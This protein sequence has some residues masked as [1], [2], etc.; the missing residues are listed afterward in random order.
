M[1]LFILTLL[2]H[3]PAFSMD[4]DEQN[5]APVVKKFSKKRA[6]APTKTAPYSSNNKKIKSSKKR[7]NAPT[8]TETAPSW[9]SSNNKI[10]IKTTETTQIGYF[11]GRNLYGYIDRSFTNN[12]QWQIALDKGATKTAKGT[13]GVKS[14]NDNVL[15]LKINANERLYATG[16]HKNDVGDYVAIFDRVTNHEGITKLANKKNNFKIYEDCFR[17]SN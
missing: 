7:A 10:K 13:N 2:S 11:E 3:T 8:P 14:I 6:N 12:P 16:V 5:S 4:V 9:Y 1:A 15:E 17:D